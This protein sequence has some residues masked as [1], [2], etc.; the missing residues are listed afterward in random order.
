MILAKYSRIDEDKIKA[1]NLRL[2]QV[3]EMATKKSQKLDAESTETMA[4]QIELDKTAQAFRQVHKEREE[5]IGQWEHTL[6]Q[7]KRRDAEMDRCAEV[8]TYIHTIYKPPYL[9]TFIHT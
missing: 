2:E 6:E 3:Q 5:L 9:H 8:Y 1:L 7:M 4:S